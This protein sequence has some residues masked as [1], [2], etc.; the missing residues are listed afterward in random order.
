LCSVIIVNLH[1]Y[2]SDSLDACRTLV[3]ADATRDMP[4]LA[5]AGRPSNQ[6]FMIALAV[7]P[8][9]GDH[10]IARSAG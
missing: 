10:S 6:Q 2:P 7:K 8:C 9:D 1:T 5:I 4:I 3:S